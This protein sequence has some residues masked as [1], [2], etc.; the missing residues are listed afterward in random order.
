ENLRRDAQ[1]NA[2]AARSH[3]PQDEMRL[4]EYLDGELTDEQ[5][6]AVAAHLASCGECQALSQ[7][8]Q[9]LDAELALSVGHP[10]LS[11]DFRTRL[12]ERIRAEPPFVSG[13]ERKRKRLQLEAQFEQQWKDYRKSFFRA[14]LP[15]F[16]DY[17]GYG[18]M[19]G[20][21]GCVLF[22]LM[23]GLL[24]VVHNAPGA[25]L[26][27]LLP[28]IAAG[29]VAMLF[30]GALAFVNRDRCIRWQPEL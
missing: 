15:A 10:I 17:L 18:T 20:I 24:R 13:D 9:Q 30:F 3:L 28:P 29:T 23:G 25:G 16:L 5:A 7:Q 22:L 26:Q 2:P 1:S 12:T 11:P 6:K 27:Q 8:W 4:F 14:Q 19:C 21:A